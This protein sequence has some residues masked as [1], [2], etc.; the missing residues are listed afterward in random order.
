MF[1]SRMSEMRQNIL[2]FER[3]PIL[4][5]IY[6]TPSNKDASKIEATLT[7]HS[8]TP[9]QLHLSAK[10]KTT[11]PLVSQQQQQLKSTAQKD[12]METIN[13][14]VERYDEYK[15]KKCHLK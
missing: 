3:A 2:H 13:V 8:L 15:P 1:S 6:Q 9:G 4:V 10:T 5:K 7:I 11:T 14:N 12:T